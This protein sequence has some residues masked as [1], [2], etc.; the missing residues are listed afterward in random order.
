M[1]EDFFFSTF[2]V[3]FMRFC[4]A[5]TASSAIFLPKSAWLFSHSSNGSRTIC[6]TSL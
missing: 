3:D 1:P 6:E 4:A 5:L 2:C